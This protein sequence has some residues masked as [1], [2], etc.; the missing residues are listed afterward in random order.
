MLKRISLGLLLA[1]VL[2]L[3]AVVLR[4]LATP[5]QQLAVAP[6]PRPDI[7]LQAAARRLSTAITF[8]TVSSLED[9]AAS[10][11]EFDKLHVYLE[12]QFPKVHATLK[13]E[14][15]GQKALLYT[16]PGTDPKD[17]KSVV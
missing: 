17:R 6:A 12:R 1:I 2:L 14:V 9:P 3:A 15:V 8:R 16:W 5:S 7:D 10:L 11:A 13:K 4:T